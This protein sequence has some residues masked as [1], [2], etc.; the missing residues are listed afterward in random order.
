LKMA[1]R[2]GEP[3]RK[4]EGIYER[5]PQPPQ[6]TRLSDKF[7]FRSM[8]KGTVVRMGSIAAKAPA[9]GGK[10]DPTQP[11]VAWKTNITWFYAK[12]AKRGQEKMRSMLKKLKGTSR[13]GP[14]PSQGK[15]FNG[16]QWTGKS[17]AI[18]IKKQR[19]PGC[20]RQV[21]RDQDEVRKQ[22]GRRGAEKGNRRPKKEGGFRG[23]RGFALCAGSSRRGRFIGA[24]QGR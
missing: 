4:Q 5:E 9:H 1:R 18:G 21:R 14:F 2:K 10:T 3:V 20:G 22:R 13:V 11:G 6:R 7:H 24:L 8:G 23:K 17:L 16:G 19:M 15:G 12:S